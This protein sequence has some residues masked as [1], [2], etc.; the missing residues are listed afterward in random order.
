[1]EYYVLSNIDHDGKRYVRG[2]RIVVSDTFAAALIA[3]GAIQTEPLEAV[4]SL[5]QPSE[6]AQE[7]DSV[8]VGG[9]AQG[10]GEPSLD[11][12]QDRTG[13]DTAADVTPKVDE[14]EAPAPVAAR[15]G[16]LS[17]LFGGDASKDTAATSTA[18]TPEGQAA[19]ADPSANL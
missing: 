9:K 16:V 6:P 19:P 4:E 5:R 8:T 14:P 12:T 10:T 17:K 1:M 15:P 3:A 11:G 18:V 13:A 2:D 7:A